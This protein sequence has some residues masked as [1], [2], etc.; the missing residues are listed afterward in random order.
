[1]QASFDAV[2]VGAGPAGTT[3]AILLARAGWSVALLER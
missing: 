2:I 1:M 3:A